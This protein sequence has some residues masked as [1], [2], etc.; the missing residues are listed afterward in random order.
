[1]RFGMDKAA[2]SGRR[3]REGELLHDNIVSSKRDDEE[4]AEETS[5]DR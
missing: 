5:A 1:M 4:H 3:R 2:Y